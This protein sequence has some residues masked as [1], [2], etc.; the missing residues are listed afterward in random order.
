MPNQNNTALA[1]QISSL[2]R[3]TY[4]IRVNVDLFNN[5]LYKELDNSAKLLYSLYEDRL[6]CSVHMAMDKQ[7]FTYVDA[8]RGAFIWFSVEDAATILGIGSRTVNK[9]NKAL[10]DLGLIARVKTRNGGNKIFV[11]PV[12]RTPENADLV[13]AWHNSNDTFI[14]EKEAEK[15][16]IEPSAK[17]ALGQTQNLRLS[18]SQPS[19]SNNQDE[20]IQASLTP[21]EQS[22]KVANPYWDLSDNVRTAYNGE[23][24]FINE[25]TATKLINLVNCYGEECVVYAIEKAT[26][27]NVKFPLGYLTKTIVS[28]KNAGLT[29]VAAMK[30]ADQERSRK[31]NNSNKAKKSFNR[32]NY[33]GRKGKKRIKEQLPD[34]AKDGAK[35]EYKAASAESTA[36]VQQLLADLKSSDAKSTKKAVVTTQI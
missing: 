20:M 8:Q 12:V 30:Q 23:F 14:V 29:T 33:T 21:V 2:G 18:N 10:E 11:N 24:G 5:E 26:G 16:A 17:S 6:R 3:S 7:D 27:R 36:K 1:G 25:K 31:Q 13:M 19:N 28:A 22:T 34:W 15:P 35:R 32:G 9:L 4:S